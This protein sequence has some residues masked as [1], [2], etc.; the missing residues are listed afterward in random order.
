MGKECRQ[1]LFTA[2]YGVRGDLLQVADGFSCRRCDGTIQE[3]DL[4]EDLMVDGETCG[5]VKSFSYLGDTL[6]DGDQMIG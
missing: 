3:A 2:R 5:C 6:V 4:H 1:T